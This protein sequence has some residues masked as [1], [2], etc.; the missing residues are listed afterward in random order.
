MNYIA[1]VKLD[2]DDPEGDLEDLGRARIAPQAVDP[3]LIWMT[4]IYN[5]NQTPINPDGYFKEIQQV[6]QTIPDANKAVIIGEQKA[7]AIHFDGYVGEL[8][9]VQVSSLES[10]DFK[11]KNY[12]VELK[13]LYPNLK[14]Y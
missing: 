1:L 2:I 12:D 3:S 5:V 6:Y 8:T 10:S 14:Y 11:V 7:A 13:L 9:P 4:L